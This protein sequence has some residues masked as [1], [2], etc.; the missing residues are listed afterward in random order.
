[1]QIR[2]L[3]MTR[4]LLIFAIAG[5]AKGVAGCETTQVHSTLESEVVVQTTQERLSTMGTAV[6]SATDWVEDS[7][8]TADVFRVMGL[9]DDTLSTGEPIFPLNPGTLSA[10][11]AELLETRVLL[12]SNVVDADE[13]SVTLSLIHI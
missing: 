12:P 6:D 13:H 2:N 1:M 10:D 4:I 7:S 8:F 5:L 11:L 3:S 9:G